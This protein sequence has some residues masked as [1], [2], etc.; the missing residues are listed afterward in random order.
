M[1]CHVM[2]CKFMMQVSYVLDTEDSFRRIKPSSGRANGVD[3]ASQRTSRFNDWLRRTA[4][5]AAAAP[6]AALPRAPLPPMAAQPV[7]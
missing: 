3:A 1:L 6:A 7:I 2:L 5:A 4:E